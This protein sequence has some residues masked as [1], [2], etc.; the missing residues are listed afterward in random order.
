METISNGQLTISVAKHGAELQS[1]KDNGGHEYLWQANKDYWGKHSP[2]LFPL[3]CGVW[4]DT[5]RIDG[6]LFHMTK[7]GFARDNDFI[8]DLRT[9]RELSFTFESNADTLAK[10][11][12]RFRLT[13]GYRLEGRTL[14]VLWTVD[15]T[16]NRDIYFQIGGHPAFNVPGME[17]GQSLHGF[18]KFDN[19]NAQRLY[20]NTGGCITP[21]HHPLKMDGD[22]WEFRMEDFDDDAL[23][24][25]E[26]QLREVQL[27]NN[28]RQPVVTVSFRSPA[29]G[30]WSPTAKNAPFICIE[31]WYGLH[32]WAGYEGEFRDK[33]LMNK[34]LPGASF[35]SEYT[36]T[37]H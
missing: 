31:P 33:Y 4:K 22:V 36:I 28:D 19:P 20:G 17:E 15:N 1:I 35:K 34:L 29:L 16:D 8:L 9:E 11:P 18:L 7:H 37:I 13:V 26:C 21:G 10:Y 24:F 14:H 6:K 25:D 3:V 27:L 32:D 2:I 23:I 5:F 12:Y 30:I